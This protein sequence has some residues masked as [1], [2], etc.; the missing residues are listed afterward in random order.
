MTISVFELFKIGVGP[1]SSHTVGPMIAARRFCV[2]LQDRGLLGRAAH[3]R[4]DFYGSLAL[5]GKGHGSDTAVIAGLAGESPDR[6]DPGATAAIVAQARATGRLS[7]LG[8]HEVAFDPD[9]D[10]AFHQRERLPFHSNALAFEAYDPA[11][12]LLLR[13]TYYSVGGGFVVD[14]DEAARNDR[15]DADAAPIPYPFSSGGGTAG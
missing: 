1:S 6:T 12:E 10:L 3:V 11:G 4:C 7:L 13:R 5:T 15:D 2:L 8:V 14:E 9:A